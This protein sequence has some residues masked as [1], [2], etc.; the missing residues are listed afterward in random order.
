MAK[1]QTKKM[2]RKLGIKCSKRESPI[3]NVATSI[4]AAMAMMARH[5]AIGEHVLR[6]N[7][8]YDHAINQELKRSDMVFPKHANLD[9]EQIYAKLLLEKWKWKGKG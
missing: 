6:R 2:L 9:S 5:R 8:A 7:L 3:R 4:A 1:D